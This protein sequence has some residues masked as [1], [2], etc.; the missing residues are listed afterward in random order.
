MAN[1]NSLKNAALIAPTTTPDLGSETNRY[2]NVFMSGNI[3][4]SGTSLTSTN[5]ITP[6]V[7]SIGYIGDD[8]AA[9]IAGGQTIT[10]NGTGFVNGA[11]ILIAGTVVGV[12]TFISATQLTFTSPAFAAGSY[13]MYVI[14]PDGGTALS[15]PG[16]QYSGTPSW[17]TTAGALTSVGASASVSIT[18]AATGDAPVTYSLFSGTLP[19]GVTLNSTTGFLSGTSPAVSSSTTYNFTIRATDAQNQDTNRSFSLTVN[20]AVTVEYLVVAGGGSGGSKT[21]GGGGGAGGVLN[22]NFLTSAGSTYTVTVGQGGAG[23]T[24]V[25]DGGAS[26]ANSVFATI[27]A[28]GGGGGMGNYGVLPTGSKNGGSGGG[29]GGTATAGGTGIAGQGNAGGLGRAGGG[30]YGAGGG[31]AG[32]VGEDGQASRGGNGGVGQY[33]AQFTSAG[34]PSGWYGGG[35][36]GAAD[37]N[38]GTTIA[39]GGGGLTSYGTGTAGHA[40]A[41][42]GGGGACGGGSGTAAPGGNGGSGIVI[43]RYEDTYPAASATTGSPTITVAGGYRVYKFTAS[44][45]ITF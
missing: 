30:G 45:S 10:L 44:G 7:S 32:A 9:D 33:F 13:V 22:G 39:S 19:T 14:N 18:L 17:T 41:N 11:S 35:G 37:N 5:V 42:T 21:M 23:K 16:I 6:K 31:G 4:M 36:S 25:D 1:Y 27:T 40:V 38:N 12:V 28:A 26:G 43:I 24:G 29:G 15:L 8:T 2:G 3:N 34:F 20:S